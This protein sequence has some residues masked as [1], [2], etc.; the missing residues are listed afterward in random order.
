MIHRPLLTLALFP[1]FS[2]LAGIAGVFTSNPITGDA[3]SGISADKAYTLA[4][5]IFDGPN[6]RINDAVFTGSG[7]GGN[8]TTN[9]YTTSGLNNGFT[10]NVPPIT[11]NVGGLTQNFLYNGN[12]ATYT[13]KNLRVGET[14]TTTFFNAA[15]GGPGGRIHNVTASDGGVLNGFDQNA[16]PGSVLKYTFTAAANSITFAMTPLVPADTWHHYAVSNE[17]VKQRALLTDNFYAPSNPNTLDLNFNLAARQGGLLTTGGGTIPWVAVNNTQVGNG[18]GGIDGGNYLLNAFG[19]GRS[20]L[21]YNFNGSAS[22]GG[23]AVSFDLA[24]NSVANPD[25]TLW[26]A[27]NIGQSSAN[28]NDGINDPH[29]HFGILFRGNGLLQAFDG[30]TVLTPVEPIWSETAQTNGLTRIELIAQDPTDGNPFD[31]V[32]QTDISVYAGGILRYS[33]SKTGGGYAD[34][35]LNFSAANIGGVDNLMVAQLV[36]EPGS[37]GLLALTG[38]LLARRRRP[39]AR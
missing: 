1:L 35:Y 9:N 32:G 19:N 18:T 4:V 16:T 33:F 30:N 3:D 5:D 10:G 11:G 31:G 13:L 36:P 26:E 28:K 22:A 39:A 20:A 17:I 25:A 8:P 14:Y 37:L 24:P 6:R 27:V 23:L 2:P 12:P 38:G 15:F 21:D 29:S 34:N 7:G